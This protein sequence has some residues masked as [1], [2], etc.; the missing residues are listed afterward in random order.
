[1]GRISKSLNKLREK[2]TEAGT[3]PAGNSTA[4]ILEC[5]AEHFEAG[6]SLPEVTSDDNGK[7]LK[8]ANGAWDKGEAGSSLP[9]VTDADNGKVLGVANGVWDKINAQGGGGELYVTFTPASAISEYKYEM[10]ADKTFD[11]IIAAASGGIQVKAKFSLIPPVAGEYSA[12]LPLIYIHDLGGSTGWDIT[13]GSLDV[14]I[15]NVAGAISSLEYTEIRGSSAENKWYL[16][17]ATHDLT[18]E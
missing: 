8:V 15:G 12:A 7:V 3:H 11:E 17:M 1:M 9:A 14:R 4:D 5:I 13:F 18:E 2:C 10:T 6:S 16:E